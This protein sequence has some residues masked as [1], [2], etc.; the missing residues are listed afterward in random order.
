[1][2]DQF[3]TEEQLFEQIKRLGG[4]QF[5]RLTLADW[6]RRGAIPKPTGVGG[7][8][9]RR[10]YQLSTAAEFVAG[11]ELLMA[12]ASKAYIRAARE[13]ALAIERCQGPADILVIARGLSQEAKGQNIEP[14]GSGIVAWLRL[15]R[16][17]LQ[18]L[19]GKT[20]P[21]F[22]KRRDE[23]FNSPDFARLV[24][25]VVNKFYDGYRFEGGRLI[26]PEKKS[27]AEAEALKNFP[28][29]KAA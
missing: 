6:A 3:I 22:E 4:R 21:E 10:Q 20:E 25:G 28:K 14:F 27:V 19:Y 18:D 13:I 17:Y 12:G 23:Y 26:A 2:M 16:K 5:S 7:R 9:M 24:F 8:G 15:K 11:M 29:A 1:M